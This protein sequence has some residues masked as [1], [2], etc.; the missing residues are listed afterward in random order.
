MTSR[1][2]DCEVQCHWAVPPEAISVLFCQMKELGKQQFTL[3]VYERTCD[4]FGWAFDHRRLH[5]SIKHY[6]MPRGGNIAVGY[7]DERVG[8]AVAD[9]CYVEIYDIEGLSPDEVANSEAFENAYLYA[10]GIAQ[11]AWGPETIVGSCPQ[12]SAKY[13]LWKRADTMMASLKG[14]DDID[15]L[16]IRVS[17]E[18]WPHDPR[19]ESDPEFVFDALTMGPEWMRTR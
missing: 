9:L 11:N 2:T 19:I 3:A 4:A 15:C 10:L 7:R 14:A 18:P 6:Q 8:Y 13:C 5:P 16:A 1:T 17:V 12:Y